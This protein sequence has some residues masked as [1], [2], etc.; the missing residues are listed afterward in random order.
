MLN[1]T[2]LY[3]L[4]M[5]LVC[6]ANCSWCLSKQNNKNSIRE[7]LEL[8][9]IF[10][11]NFKKS[12]EFLKTLP[13]SKLEFTGGGEPFLNKNLNDI[14]VFVKHHFPTLTLSYTLTVL[15]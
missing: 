10:L 1:K 8:D 4:P 2:K 11:S 15:S 6:N 14:I 13:I 7:K 5:K 12:Y 9:E 3:I